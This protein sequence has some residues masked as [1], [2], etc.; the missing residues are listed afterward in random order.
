M[1]FR[2]ESFKHT[3]Y[4]FIEPKKKNN[5]KNQLSKEEIK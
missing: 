2:I 3:K 4:K 5:N 1:N